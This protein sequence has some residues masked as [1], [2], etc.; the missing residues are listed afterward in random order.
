MKNFSEKV[1]DKAELEETTLRIV[2]Y[3]R[4]TLDSI[5]D[6]IKIEDSIAFL[7]FRSLEDGLVEA[8]KLLNKMQKMRHNEDMKGEADY[9]AKEVFIKEKKREVKRKWLEDR[10]FTFEV[11]EHFSAISNEEKK[12]TKEFSKVWENHNEKKTNIWNRWKQLHSN[13]RS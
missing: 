2:H 4:N 1:T 9:E 6:T 13:T 10:D 11:G 5:M 3:C 8:D 7:M 12:N